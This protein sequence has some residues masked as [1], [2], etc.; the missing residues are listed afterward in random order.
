MLLFVAWEND[1]LRVIDLSR[2]RL[3]REVAVWK[4]EGRAAGAAPFHAWQLVRHRN[5][6]LVSSLSE[7]AVHILRI[8]PGVAIAE[9]DAQ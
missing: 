8:D 5:L 4:G 6:I 1:G 2:P 7:A 3:P 9:E